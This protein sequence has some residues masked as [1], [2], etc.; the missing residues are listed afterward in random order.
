MV[1]CEFEPHVQLFTVSADP[2]SDPLFPSLLCTSP[3]CLSC[4]LS[5]KQIN[6]KK[7][8][9]ETE[10]IGMCLFFLMFIYFEGG[11]AEKEG[12]R[13]PSKLHA[14]STEPSVGLH[15]MNCEIIT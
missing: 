1:V 3:A 6:L 8:E 11:G 5:Q 2:A 10:S 7:R 15:P 4:S 14:L 13:N 12:E 9:R